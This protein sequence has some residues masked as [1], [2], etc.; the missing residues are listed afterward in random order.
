MARVT[1]RISDQKLYRGEGRI[2]AMRRLDKVIKQA[3]TI[4]NE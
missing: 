1:D 3:D 2:S 4:P